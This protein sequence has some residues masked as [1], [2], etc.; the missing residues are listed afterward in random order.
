VA[1]RLL[2][3]GFSD[4]L[5][6]PVPLFS[7]AIELV[8]SP[9]RIFGL[10]EDLTRA[11]LRALAHSVGAPA[12]PSMLNR[13]ISSSRHLAFLKRPLDDLKQIARNNSRVTINDV[14]LAAACGGM[15]RF[16]IWHGE[17]P[18]RLKT[19]VPSSPA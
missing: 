2:T 4:R 10:P 5:L 8:R 9:K 13:P 16:L 12:L 7:A 3:E 17:Q 11:L 6:D 18:I 19:M 14:V 1:V 15:R